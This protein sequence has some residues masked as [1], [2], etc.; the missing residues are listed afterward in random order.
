M[1]K[2][3]TVIKFAIDAHM[4]QTRK[5]SKA[6]YIIH[7]LE[8]L[9]IAA[10][11]TL[12]EDVLCATVLHDVVEDTPVSIEEIL[13]AFGDRV[14]FLVS[15]ETENKYEGVPKDVSWRARKE[16]TLALLKKSDD[17]GVKIMWMSDKLSNMRA[18]LIEYIGKGEEIWKFFN[19]K[20]KKQHEW[21]YRSI[22]E[23]L[24]PEF[25][26]T[27]AFME[28]ETIINYIFAGKRAV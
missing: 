24:R 3:E 7:P 18:M 19:Q 21:Y 13:K 11:L 17:I 4:G 16:E 10:Q 2:L 1:S 14:A 25:E 6:P 15:C 12:D 22:A 8:A 20:D 23:I 26:N 5:I 28:Y 9:S 27:P